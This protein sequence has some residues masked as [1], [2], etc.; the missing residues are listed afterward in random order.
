M[1][2]GRKCFDL[3]ERLHRSQNNKSGLSGLSNK[4]AFASC[5]TKPS[6][7]FMAQRLSAKATDIGANLSSPE[8]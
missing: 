5:P 3:N 1:R 8:T 4:P 7:A 6:R 2:S